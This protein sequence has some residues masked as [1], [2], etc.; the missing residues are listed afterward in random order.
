MPVDGSDVSEGT[1]ADSTGHYFLP[2]LRPG[3]YKLLAGGESIE[4]AMRAGFAEDDDRFVVVEL[5]LGDNVTQDL[6]AI[7]AAKK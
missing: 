7:P 5:H 1:T 3:K 2:N 6:K 4:G